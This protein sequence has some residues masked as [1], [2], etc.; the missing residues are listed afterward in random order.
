MK[1]YIAGSITNNCDYALD[2]RRI[3]K[4]LLDQGHTPLNPVKHLGF[5][6]KEYIDMG[7]NE[8]MHCDAILLLDNWE[9]SIGARL[10]KH[11]AETVGM[12]VLHESE[13]KKIR[14]GRTCTIK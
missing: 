3:E 14:E 13:V 10:E 7:L 6:Y 2:F 9:T 12:D 4:I 1:I 11:Y 8:L 5:E